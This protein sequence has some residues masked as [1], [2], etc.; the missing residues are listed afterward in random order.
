M[1][2]GWI[3]PD[4]PAE[5]Q[6]SHESQSQIFLGDPQTPEY[7][8][9]CIENINLLKRKFQLESIPQVIV[10]DKNQDLVAKDV[11]DDLLKLHP[12]TCRMVWI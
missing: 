11:S 4:F 5:I 3:Y 10:L 6:D 2:F 12:E 9:K 8:D 1:N 7:M